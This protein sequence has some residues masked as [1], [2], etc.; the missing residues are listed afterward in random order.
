VQGNQVKAVL[1]LI[2]DKLG[3]PKAFVEVKDPT[4]GKGKGGK[5]KK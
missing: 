2:C 3:V 4:A 5:K 1:N